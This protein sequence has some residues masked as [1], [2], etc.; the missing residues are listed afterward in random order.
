[1]VETATRAVP[2]ADL[3]LFMVDASERP[4]DEDLQIAEILQEQARVPILLILNKVDLLTPNEIENQTDTYSRLVD[5]VDTVRISAV[6]GM[7]TER[8]LDVVI[9]CLPAGP[10]YYPPDQ[11]TDQP[12]RIIGAE[13]IREQ[14][15]NFTHQEVPHAVAVVVDEWKER[16]EDLTYISATIY[17]EKDS[18]KKI[19]IGARGSMLKQI[20]QA[21]RQELERFVG[22]RVFLDLWVKVRKNWRKDENALRWLGYSLPKKG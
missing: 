15:L 9:E 21:A 12:E 8:L 16:R 5:A 10:Q 22:H 2:D 4:A 14:V 19:V 17:V 20:G 3:I 11:I 13:L 18:Q 7:G 1:M 6:E